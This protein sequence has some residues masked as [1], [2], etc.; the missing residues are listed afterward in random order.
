MEYGGRP[1]FYFYSKFMKN[2][3][4]TDWLGREDMECGTDEELHQAV[5]DIR[6][7][8]EEYKKL[9][10]LQ[11]E[12]IEKHVQKKEGV[13]QVTYSNQIVMEVDYNV[14]KVHLVG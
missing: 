12:F 7:A 13:F 14:G 9:R 1:T 8:Y 4:L 6:N 2:S 10:H 5:C 3:S 11:Y